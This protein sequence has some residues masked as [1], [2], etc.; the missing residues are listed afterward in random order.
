[1]D[2]SEELNLISS[3]PWESESLIKKSPKDK[4]EEQVKY[5][6]RFNAVIDISNAALVPSGSKDFCLIPDFQYCFT[7]RLY[8]LKIKLKCPNGDIMAL[9]VP[10]ILQKERE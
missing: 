10:L 6:K 7:A 5:T 4:V 8:Y 2:S 3:I 1:M 9:K